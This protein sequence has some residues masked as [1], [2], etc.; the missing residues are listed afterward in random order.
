MKTCIEQIFH[1]VADF[2][3]SERARYFAACEID[4]ETRSEVE[5]LLAFDAPTTAS[6][7]REIRGAASA[8]LCRMNPAPLDC[9]P[10]RLRELLGRGGMGSVYAA[11][12]ADGE[13]NQSV[14]I[15]LLRPGADDPRLRL[16]F[17]SERQIL[18][19]LS[20]PNIARLLDAGH[21][22]DGLPYL[23]MEYVEGQPIDTYS[24][25][26]DT[27][28]KVVL[29]LKVCGAVAYLHRNLVI[30]RDLKPANI[31]VSSEGEPK[32]LDF[33]I[34]KMIDFATDSTVTG[35]RMLTP[36]Y[37]SPEQV[38]G[39]APTTA[40]DVYSLGAVLYK[41]LTGSP[42]HHF[43][44]HSAAAI[45]AGICA[46]EIVPPIER[47]R[48]LDRD[49]VMIVMKA[50][51]REPHERYATVE[52]LAEDLE[53]FL[54]SRP[55]RA[56]RGD[57]G[58]RLRKFARRFWIPVAAATLA[59]ASLS[60][61]L[62]IALRERANAQ[63]RFFEVRQLA[64]RLFDI[65]EEV[66]KV[67]GNARTRQMIVDTAL[68]YLQ[69]LAPAASGDPGLALEVGTAYMRVA[70]VQGVPLS[71]N[72]GQLDQAE[73]NL[74]IAQSFIDRVPN[75]TA[76]LREAQIAH[77]RMLIGRQR[78]LDDQSLVQI[79]R[80]VDRWLGKFQAGAADSAEAGSILTIYSTTAGVFSRAWK[81]D[82]A[83]RLC[84]RGE[85]L[86]RAFG[87]KSSLGAFYGL[88]GDTARRQGDLDEALRNIDASVRAYT[89][90]DGNPDHSALMGY[91]FAL[92]RLGRVLGDEHGLSLGRKKE[93]TDALQRAFDLA[94]EFA[95]RDPND[96]ASRNRIGLA[97]VDLGK[98]LQRTDPERA[99]ALYDHLLVHA[100]EI[101][102]NQ[103]FRRFEVSALAGSADALRRLG[104][105]GEARDRINQALSRLRGLGDYPKE[106]IG[107]SSEVDE[108]L[109]ALAELQADTGNVAQAIA[110]Y[111]QLLSGMLAWP[112]HP[113]S[114]LEDACDLSRVYEALAALGRR[115]GQSDLAAR[116]EVQRL[117]IWQQWSAR[118]PR[119][120]YIRS[121]LNAAAP[122]AETSR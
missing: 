27:R 22:E 82:D 93:A 108:T 35:F 18:A 117:E 3:A 114:N 73:K 84:A 110:T 21:R 85:E 109:S 45:E 69:R 99:V 28:R 92:I 15:K 103:S 50:L 57:I 77:D 19:A 96:Q 2:S 62:A 48:G 95:H 68:A 59:A 111:Q 17:L 23:V 64:G 102:E 31:L 91:T 44:D 72:L 71:V 65:D 63:R 121:Q 86:A 11:E 116:F 118:L 42:P 34:A 79:A 39:A 24:A 14:A 70:H 26:L 119:N 47:K 104:R 33:G 60:T 67:P 80:E 32:L 56:R 4:A 37:A 20:H 83:L 66:R 51:R 49:L 74:A 101:K 113:E 52:Q 94:D 7:D 53:N 100:A 58:Y 122:R 29:F 90:G 55:I 76:M 8:A 61:G 106:R 6:L 54:E 9:G 98:I 89:P 10:Y 115:A 75:R 5:A 13:V 88:A 105:R 25:Q 87:M 41:L 38:T 1:A 30:H 46:G 120:S 107:L 43:E 112:P 16:R 36:D 12:R 40:T 78:N 81:F 97:A